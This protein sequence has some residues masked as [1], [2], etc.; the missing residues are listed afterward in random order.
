MRAKFAGGPY[1]NVILQVR[2]TTS[3]L[4]LPITVEATIDPNQKVWNG[5]AVYRYRHGNEYE[6]TY[7]F[8]R[9]EM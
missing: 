4:R 8:D 2:E 1:D 5:H 9:L 6:R 3:D 7:Y